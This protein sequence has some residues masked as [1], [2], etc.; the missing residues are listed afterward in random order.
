M[1]DIAK[2]EDAESQIR[3]AEKVNRALV[4]IVVPAFPVG[5]D[6]ERLFDVMVSSDG[7]QSWVMLPTAFDGSSC[8][9]DGYAGVSRAVVAIPFLVESMEWEL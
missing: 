9:K 5:G 1:T 2:Y 3:S 6:K 7:G 4:R 8:L